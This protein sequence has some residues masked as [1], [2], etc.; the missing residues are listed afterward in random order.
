M[1]PHG[2]PPRHLLQE[3]VARALAED[4]GTGDITT[5][6]LF[7]RSVLASGTIVA[8]EQGG[9]VLAGLL[10]AQ[11]VFR[12]VD[13]GLL[14]QPHFTDG[15]LV[16]GETVVLSIQGDGRSM[17]KGERV[18]LNFLQRLSGI[19]TLTAAFRDA[20]KGFNVKIA[21]TRK[22]SPGL[23]GLEKWAVRMG[24]GV[25]HRAGLGD[26]VLIKDNHI[27]LAGGD[28]TRACRLVRERAPHGLKIEVEARSLE[29]VTAALAGQADIIL[30]DNMDSGT[31]RKAVELIKG[32]ALIEVS[33][34]VTLGNIRELA[35][36]GPDLISIGA[37]THSAPAVNLSMDISG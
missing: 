14:C 17:L 7:D 32:R 36:A 4:L 8:E 37:L 12:Q 31:I 11:E 28:V 10:V 13:A 15:D 22:T 20:V 16:P 26:G 24:G 33:G 3:V 23:R 27:A 21:D 35:S 34:G 19:A 25:N 29:E 2:D 9:L 1:N 5:D 18:A 30:L 6:A